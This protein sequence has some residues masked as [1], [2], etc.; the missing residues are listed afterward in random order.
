M[1]SG[2]H[3][4]LWLSPGP[5]PPRVARLLSPA[6][7]SKELLRRPQS[8]SPSLPPRPPTVSLSP[9]YLSTPSSNHRAADGVLRGGARRRAVLLPRRRSSPSLSIP[10]AEEQGADSGARRSSGSEAEEETEW[11]RLILPFP[12]RI[13]R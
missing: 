2:A 5:N 12:A 10:G 1:Q 8:L 7:T 4:P 6:S 11:A 9:T 13:N 3:P